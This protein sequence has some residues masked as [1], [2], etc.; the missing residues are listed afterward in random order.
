MTPSHYCAALLRGLALRTEAAATLRMNPTP[1]EAAPGEQ[2]GVELPQISDH[3][4]ALPDELRQQYRKMLTQALDAYQEREA[5]L[6]SVVEIP[7]IA[8][9][10]LTASGNRN[11]ENTTGRMAGR[12][13]LLTGAAQGIGAGIA[14]EL[15]AEGACILL[16]DIN[17][18]ALQE[19]E[20]TI[21]QR[22]GQQPGQQKRRAA[23]SFVADIS[24]EDSV[25]QLYQYLSENLGGFDMLISNA[26]ILRAGAV[27]QLDYEDFQKVQAVNYTGYFLLVKYA[28]AILR[29][30]HEGHGSRHTDII[31]INSKSG[32]KGSNRNSA[33]A[34]SKFGG[35]GLTQSFAL[36]LA[37]DNIK[38]NAICPG[39]FFDGP[40]WSHPEQGLFVQYLQSGKVPGARTV[41]DVRRHYES[42]IPMK[43]G[44]SPHDIVIAILYCL[45]QK[46]ETGQAIPVTGGQEMIH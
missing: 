42:L 44:C 39:N 9:Y 40:L 45:E 23:Y 6:P 7:G 4:A 22:H 2:L 46:Y 31:Q 27:D 43:R 18:E 17:S 41:E 32:L 20:D 38:V 8:R 26:G 5:R 36:E 21:N 1:N 30:Q 10:Q 37:M 34:G 35:L 25:R 19:R 29:A 13:V 15:A 11:R 28:A 16:V 3:A 33:Y 24:N 12:V 14:D